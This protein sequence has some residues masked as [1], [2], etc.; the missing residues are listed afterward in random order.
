MALWQALLTR[1]TLLTV[2][3]RDIQC[4]GRCEPLALVVGG[5]EVTDIRRP[6]RHRLPRA[7]QEGG[8]ALRPTQQQGTPGLGDTQSPDASGASVEPPN[9]DDVLQY[10]E[11]LGATAARVM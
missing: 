9:Q 7:A 10:V 3:S 1:P 5:L 11:E 2:F 6:S 4:L 8:C